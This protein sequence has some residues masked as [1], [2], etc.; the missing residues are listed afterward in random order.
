MSIRL[1]RVLQ[2][3]FPAVAVPELDQEG[4][5]TGVEGEETGLEGEEMEGEGTGVE[6]DSG[7]EVLK[8]LSLRALLETLDTQ[9]V[10]E[11]TKGLNHTT[12]W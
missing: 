2:T 3:S 7:V 5:E 9:P 6:E 12:H 8:V 1:Q 4:E 10:E 11:E